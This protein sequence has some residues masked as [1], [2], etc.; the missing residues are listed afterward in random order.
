MAA[1]MVTR[2]RNMTCKHFSV[3][4]SPK[5]QGRPSEAALLRWVRE[6][7]DAGVRS[8]R[9]RRRGSRKPAGS[10]RI[11]DEARQAAKHLRQFRRER[12]AK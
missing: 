8:L 2:C 3:E 4:R 1:V 10:R 5:I 11:V 9:L 12:A 6:A 7:A